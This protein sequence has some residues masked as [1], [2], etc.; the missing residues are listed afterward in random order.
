MEK[1]YGK[2][3]TISEEDIQRGL[4]ERVLSDAKPIVKSS[5]GKTHDL[6]MRPTE[7]SSGGYVDYAGDD[8]SD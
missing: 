5:I 2:V 3:E 4:L 8:P 6:Y 1:N 7:L